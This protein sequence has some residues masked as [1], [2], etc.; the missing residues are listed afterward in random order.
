MKIKTPA[1]FVL[2]L[3]LTM[4]ISYAGCSNV[5][6]ISTTSSSVSRSDDLVNFEPSPDDGNELVPLIMQVVKKPRPFRASDGL[7]HLVYELQIENFTTETIGLKKLTV[8]GNAVDTAPMLV[9]QG[10]DLIQRTLLLQY[11][12]FKKAPLD[13]VTVDQIGPGQTAVVFLDVTLDSGESVPDTLINKVEID[14]PPIIAE[15]LG[16]SALSVSAEV[17]VDKEEAL[18]L[19]Q[20]IR[21]GRWINL[22]G[23]CDFSSSAHRRV[24][25]S[26]DGK[27]FFPER[28]SI[29]IMEVD[30]ENN[31]FVG[32]ANDNKSWLGYGTELMAVSDGVVSRVVKGVPDNKPGESPPF[33]ISLSDGAGNIV[34]LHIG[35]GIYVLYAHLIPGS[36]D[37][38]EVGDFVKKGEVVGLLGNTGQSGAPHLH[39]QVMDGNSIAQAEGVPFEFEEFDNVGILLDV[40]EEDGDDEG[41]GLDLDDV[42]DTEEEENMEQ[43]SPGIILTN[44]QLLP[45]PAPRTNEHQLQFTIIGFPE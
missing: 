30:E 23:C 5:K 42:I 39:F 21:G 32:D 24:I 37:R 15:I 31:L 22:N 12:P 29:D 4:F 27:E 7:T 44:V 38:L 19:G 36:N 26:V 17:D 33:P 41:D 43:D 6:K 45:E 35:N 10:D 2:I 16:M 1:I 14:G 8:F 40:D 9:L 34:I 25:R 11:H 13:E 28:Y 3:S 18:V 20:P